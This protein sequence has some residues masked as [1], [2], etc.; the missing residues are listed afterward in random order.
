[1]VQRFVV[2]VDSINLLEQYLNVAL[3]TV[4]NS[5]EELAVKILNHSD[6]HDLFMRRTYQKKDRC[7][8]VI[9]ISGWYSSSDV[10]KHS[11]FDGS[12]PLKTFRSAETTNTVDSTILFIKDLLMV[13]GKIWDAQFKKVCG[14]GY[15]AGFNKFDGSIGLGYEL[16]SCGRFPEELSISI[17]HMYYGK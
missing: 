5:H 3:T 8:P 12:E 10:R 16:R 13:H 14:D 6:N 7:F 2:E 1:M 15:S 17:I 4:L 11:Y 9:L